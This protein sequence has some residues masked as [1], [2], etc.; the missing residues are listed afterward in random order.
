MFFN[1]VSNKKKALPMKKKKNLAF[2]TQNFIFYC[3]S[4]LGD[5]KKKF[6]KL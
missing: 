1:I 2:C 4:L 5:E 6:M 3:Q